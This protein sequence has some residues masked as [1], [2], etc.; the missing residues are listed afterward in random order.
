MGYEGHVIGLGDVNL[1]LAKAKRGYV[2]CGLLDLEVAEKLGH[3][4]AK[5]TGVS[6]VEDLLGAKITSATSHAQKKGVK[7]GMQ[8]SDALKIL[9]NP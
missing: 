4:A 6:T 3:S 1:V 7:E 5:V 8:A 9:D 2:M